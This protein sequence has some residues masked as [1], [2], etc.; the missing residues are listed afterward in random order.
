MKI[1]VVGLGAAGL[2]TMMLLEAAGHAV[3]GYEARPRLGGRLE[4]KRTERGFYDA[5]GEWIDSGQTRILSLLAT[6]DQAPAEVRDGTGWQVFRGERCDGEASF[7]PFF[8]AADL[9]ALDLD[10]VPWENV[11]YDHLDQQS[12]ADL[13]RQSMVDPRAA[14]ALTAVIRSE[15]GEELDRIS[16]L[17]WLGG[18]EMYRER[19][20]GESS[21]LKF[22]D[23]GQGFC[24][25]MAQS[26]RGP[27]H[28][29]T[30]IET[31]IQLPDAVHLQGAGVD[32]TF[33]RV[34]LTA[35]PNVLRQLHFEPPLTEDK[36]HALETF[37]V[38]RVIKVALRFETRWW[39]RRDWGG[40]FLSDTPLQQCWDGSRD[41]EA[42]LL[43]YLVG[44]AADA[45]R[46]APDPFEHLLRAL[47]DV[48][49]EARAEFLDGTLH[50]WIA[51][52]FAGGGF[53][54][55]PVGSVLG[56]WPDLM[57]PEGRI[58]FAG[59]ATSRWIGY[60]EGALESAERVAREIGI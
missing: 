28:L 38:G 42:V 23:G 21:P 12:V 7:D 29:G 55:L 44:D 19:G 15:E 39:L 5:G 57:R 51:D 27:I 1:A 37:G 54:F 47:D 24:E 3:T 60:I 17:G 50:D 52:P 33:D 46:L 45:C 59:D 31:V 35:P 26:L 9:L 34:V 6:F 2:R 22:P 58:H 40:R 18:Y 14:A 4:T 25:R 56:P 53:A 20:G 32:E 8:E 30:P 43:A 48:A 41:G 49:P 11:L 36:E 13:V 10:E 16:L